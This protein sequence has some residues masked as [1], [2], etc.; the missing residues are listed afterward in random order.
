MGR[1]GPE[2][3]SWM[4]AACGRVSRAAAVAEVAVGRDAEGGGLFSLLRGRL[5]VEALLGM[6]LRRP[7]R[8]GMNWLGEFLW[9]R[10]PGQPHSGWSA[11]RRV[12]SGEE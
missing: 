9:R 3:G 8:V 4:W 10:A 2:L 6:P 7:E 1:T 11:S 5:D 12:E